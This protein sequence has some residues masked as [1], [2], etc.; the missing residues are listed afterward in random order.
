[1][2][3]RSSASIL[4][5]RK[6]SQLKQNLIASDAIVRSVFAIV[7]LLGA[8]NCFAGDDRFEVFSPFPSLV[9]AA[10]ANQ[11]PLAQMD[12]PGTGRELSPGDSATAI[13]TLHEKKRETQW[14]VYLEAG[15]NKTA[16]TSNPPPLNIYTSLGHQFE[17]SSA[18]VDCSVRKIGPFFGPDGK[19][20][21][22]AVEDKSI[23]ISVDQGF[24]GI[25]LQRMAAATDRAITVRES[26]PGKVETNW[27]GTGPEPFKE[28]EIAKARRSDAVVQLTAE[29]ERAIAGSN[30]ALMSYFELVMQTPGL[31]DLLYKVVSLPSGWSLLRHAGIKS[32]GLKFG[33]PHPLDSQPATSHGPVYALPMDVSM[34]DHH[35]LHIQLFVTD[36]SPP[37][38]LCGGIIGLRAENPDDKDTWLAF[39]IVTAHFRAARPH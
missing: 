22:T 3:Q 28:P 1:M 31:D 17:F 33:H 11:I 39:Q 8:G 20:K 4:S 35:A 29:E 24:L 30:P 7:V 27:F 37:L 2:R 10:A 14:L 16:N 34:N 12:A 19:G 25:G 13:V 32:V 9:A 26:N 5:G 36:P 18:E 15:T 38:L 21:R 6:C 23:G